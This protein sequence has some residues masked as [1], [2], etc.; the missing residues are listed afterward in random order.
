[1]HRRNKCK[2]GEGDK[3]GQPWFWTNVRRQRRREEIAIL[4]RRRN[5][6]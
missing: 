1:M 5:R 6:K 2:R 3:G 4:S